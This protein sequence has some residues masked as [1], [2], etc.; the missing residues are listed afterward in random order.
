MRSHALT[1]CPDG[2]DATT[3]VPGSGNKNEV[4]YF[5]SHRPVGNE[6]DDPVTGRVDRIKRANRKEGK[7]RFNKKKTKK[8]RKNKHEL[9]FNAHGSSI[10]RLTTRFQEFLCTM[11]CRSSLAAGRKRKPPISRPA[12]V[13]AVRK[14]KCVLN[15]HGPKVLGLAV[16][17]S[18]AT[19][20]FTYRRISRTYSR[21]TSQ[22]EV[23]GSILWVHAIRT[24][25]STPCLILRHF[26]LSGVKTCI[27][28]ILPLTRPAPERKHTIRIR[29]MLFSV[30]LSRQR[31]H[32]Y[33]P[34]HSP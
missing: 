20:M 24:R 32:H 30:Y 17:N 11:F 3:G 19:V 34:N 9:S 8:K 4:H 1:C 10:A 23:K 18:T 7:R 5:P 15:P 29:I 21:S 13:H 25:Y 28:K 33:Y 22:L 26:P 14:D 16:V 6:V 12:C 27:F 31:L 2:S